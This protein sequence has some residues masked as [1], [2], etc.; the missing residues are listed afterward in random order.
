[1]KDL[2]KALNTVM[3][4]DLTEKQATKFEELLGWKDN[5]LIN[6]KTFCGICAFCERFFA[7]EYC[8][9]MPGR[10]ADPCHEVNIGL[11]IFKRSA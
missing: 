9:H 7:S 4:K 6:F 11:H 3:G 2:I 8:L 5:D 10:K 1:M